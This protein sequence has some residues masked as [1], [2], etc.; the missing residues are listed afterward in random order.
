MPN[1]NEITREE[2]QRLFKPD[3]AAG[4]LFWLAPRSPDIKAGDEAG[5]KDPNRNGKF[6]W[7]VRLA[8]KQYR[9]GRILF[10]MFHGRL[11]FPCLDHINGD[12]LDD[13]M[14]NIREVSQMQNMRNLVRRHSKRDLPMGV[15]H[16]NGKYQ[17]R[18]L[19]NRQM[20][21]LGVFDTPQKAA[22]AYE[23]RQQ[24]IFS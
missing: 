3:F 20:I 7:K 19:I 15:R 21:Y 23:N 24:T 4:K 6:Y 8:G 1:V 2:A 9:R 16:M 12:S 5:W 11:P 17:A 10:L 13:R 18:I 22:K 14:S